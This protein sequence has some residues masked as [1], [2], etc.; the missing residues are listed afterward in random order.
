MDEL[1]IGAQEADAFLNTADFNDDLI[2]RLVL[3]ATVHNWI[4]L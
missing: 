1:R 2:S 3:C 4:S